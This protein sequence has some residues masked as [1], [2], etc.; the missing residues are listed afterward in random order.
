MKE[1]FMFQDL[2]WHMRS[3][4][5][6]EIVELFRFRS[7]QGYMQCKNMMAKNSPLGVAIELLRNRFSVIVYSRVSMVALS[8]R[9]P[10]ARVEA[11]AVC[12]NCLTRE[13]WIVGC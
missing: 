4:K 13:S 8:S 12:Q 6:T 2:A 5:D 11:V 1:V 9:V 10:S 7:C 3:V